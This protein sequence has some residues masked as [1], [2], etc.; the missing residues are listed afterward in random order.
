MPAKRPARS[1]SI[2]D[3]IRRQRELA[4]IS[5][6]KM[7]DM[8]GVS[9]VVLG[10]IE[11]GLRNPSRTLLQSIA[12]ALRLSAETLQLQAGVID[13]QDIDEADV[14]REIHRDPHLTDR[15]RDVLVE[16]YSA[17]RAINRTRRD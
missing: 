17:F 14:V 8:S 11:Q 16:I 4:N 12:T 3:Y 10:E 9:Q 2:G 15:Q 13:P 5:L 6:R 1:S 7:A